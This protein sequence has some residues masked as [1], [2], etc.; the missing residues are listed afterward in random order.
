[1]HQAASKIIRDEG[2]TALWKGNT[3]AMGL[4]ISYSGIQFYTY[5]LIN[6]SLGSYL[7]FVLFAIAVSHRITTEHRFSAKA[8][9]FA[10]GA[11]AALASTGITYPLDLMRTQFAVQVMPFDNVVSC[12][13][14]LRWS[15]T[16]H[17]KELSQ[18]WRICTSHIFSR[19]NS[20]FKRFN[21]HRLAFMLLTSYEQLC[22]KELGL[23]WCLCVRIWAST[24]PS[25]ST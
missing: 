2:L 8:S 19:R 10:A 13:V 6:S 9:H 4:W 11:G 15:C 20:R 22:F 5:G 7:L 18:T 25:T 1:M 23:R 17:L 24:S 3:P 14:S 16:G 12:L 21:F